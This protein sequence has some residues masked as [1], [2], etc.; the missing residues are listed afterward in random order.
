MNGDLKTTFIQKSLSEYMERV[1]YTMRIAA[2]R[3]KVGVTDDAIKSLSYSAMQLGQGGTASLSF[4]NVLRFVDMGVGRAHP[5]GGLASMRVTL[6]ASNR[7]GIIQKK[8]KGR[9]PKKIYSKIAYGNLTWLENNLLYGY[10][11]ETIDALKKEL[12][13]S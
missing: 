10:T 5:L 11:Q 12:N 7:T 13:Q 8:D 9:K 1:I 4:Q 3:A 2:Q 6:Q